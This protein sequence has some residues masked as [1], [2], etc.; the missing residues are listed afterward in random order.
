[1]R[2][3]VIPG[4][5]ALAA[6]LLSVRI[7]FNAARADDIVG[8]GAVLVL[9]GIMALEYRISFKRLFGR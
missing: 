8:F 2:T 6:F 5:I 9:M 4:L 3:A 1:M 7:R